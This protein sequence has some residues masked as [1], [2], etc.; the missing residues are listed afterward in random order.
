[1]F[2]VVLAVVAPVFEPIPRPR[3]GVDDARRI[4]GQCFLS[5]L[6]GAWAG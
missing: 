2:A 6:I 4:D 1:V 5:D 3:V